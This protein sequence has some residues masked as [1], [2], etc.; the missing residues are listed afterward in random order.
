VV[1]ALLALKAMLH[2]C[3]NR[4]TQVAL[5]MLVAKVRIGSMLSKNVVF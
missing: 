3:A 2:G 4:L 5:E 1:T